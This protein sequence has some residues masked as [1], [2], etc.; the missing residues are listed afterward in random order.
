MF[1][2]CAV[3]VPTEYEQM[4]R[5]SMLEVEEIK[6]K[7]VNAMHNSYPEMML[8]EDNSSE[9][10]ACLLSSSAISKRFMVRTFGVKL[11]ACN[12]PDLQTLY[13]RVPILV[14]RSG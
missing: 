13:V 5:T 7:L 10:T 6:F 9:L 14:C 1:Q 12:F 2:F 8:D 4:V 11:P 3:P